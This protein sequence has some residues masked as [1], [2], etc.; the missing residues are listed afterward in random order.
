MDRIRYVFWFSCHTVHVSINRDL[1][2][3]MEWMQPS[4]TEGEFDRTTDRPCVDLTFSIE[5]NGSSVKAQIKRRTQQYN[6]QFISYCK[7]IYV[8]SVKNSYNAATLCHSE[9]LFCKS[10]S[11]KPNGKAMEKLEATHWHAKHKH[12]AIWTKREASNIQVCTTRLFARPSAGF[13]VFKGLSKSWRSK[14]DKN[15]KNGL[16]D[17]CF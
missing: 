1:P 13:Q 17:C 12:P 14:N 2:D 9:R 6:F 16:F 15:D 4:G 3:A 11:L 8:Y 10:A 5:T 7:I